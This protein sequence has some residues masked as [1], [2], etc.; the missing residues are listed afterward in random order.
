MSVDPKVGSTIPEDLSSKFSIGYMISLDPMVT[1][2]NT[3]L[4]S[5]WIESHRI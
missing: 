4:R 2:D 5:H 3:D 1:F